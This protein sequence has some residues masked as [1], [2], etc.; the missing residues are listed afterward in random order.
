MSTPETNEERK[1]LPKPI[2]VTPEQLRQIAAGTAAVLPTALLKPVL[3]GGITPGPIWDG[4]AATL[5]WGNRSP[6]TTRCKGW[7]PGLSLIPCPRSIPCRQKT[8]KVP[9]YCVRA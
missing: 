4:Y 2:A 5:T 7:P 1:R 3:A 9:R 8:D 6:A